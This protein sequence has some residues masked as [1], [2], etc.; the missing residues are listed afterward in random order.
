MKIAFRVDGNKKIGM[1]HVNRCKIIAKNL[2]KNNVSC[3][4]ITKFKIIF[5]YF[6]SEGFTVF[7]IKTN[8]ES[9]QVKQILKKECCSKL[10]I[11][12]KRKSIGK[13]IEFLKKEVKIILIDNSFYAKHVD[14]VVFSS[15]NNNNKIYPKNSLVGIQY[16]LHGIEKSSKHIKQNTNSILISMGGSDKYNITKKIV[17]SFSKN[18]SQFNLT[19]VLGKFSENKKQILKIINNDKRFTLVTNVPSLKSLMQESTVG[20]VTFG[21]TVFEAAVCNLPLYVISH[22]NEN[23]HSAKLVEKYGWISYVGKYDKIDYNLLTK[24]VLASLKSKKELQ[25]MKQSCKKMDGLGPLRVA[26]YIRKL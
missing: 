15:V 21:I 3:I 8:N 11:D 14:L 13:L 12:S 24:N 25:K 5:E 1:G 4:F 17:S 22:S 16:V 20:I 26:E 9:E 10:I 2:E 18:R 6:V 19:I 23:E 7:L